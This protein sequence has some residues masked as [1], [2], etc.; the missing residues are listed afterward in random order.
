MLRSLSA[1]EV[2]G[3]PFFFSTS[4]ATVFSSQCDVLSI[5]AIAGQPQSAAKFSGWSGRRTVA[6]MGCGASVSADTGL[7]TLSFEGEALPS[8]FYKQGGVGEL[9]LRKCGLGSLPTGTFSMD[10]LQ[11]LDFG[12]AMPNRVQLVHDCG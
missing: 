12:V 10:C 11:T 7:D 9:V 6:K 5:L 3:A 2:L 4:L 1:S 8:D